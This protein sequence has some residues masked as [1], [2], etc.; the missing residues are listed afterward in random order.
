MIAIVRGE[1]TI[2]IL[3]KYGLKVCVI[4]FGFYSTH[5]KMYVHLPC[6]NTHQQ[7]I[8]PFYI[9]HVISYRNHQ[10][11][12]LCQGSADRCE[13]DLNSKIIGLLKPYQI[14][15]YCN[16]LLLVIVPYLN[17]IAWSITICD[18]IL[19]SALVQ[20]FHIILYIFV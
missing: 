3:N 6:I 5:H 4:S 19:R 11:P 9:N 13:G 10:T 20:L 18:L 7:S 12:R 2:L 14:I 8:A 17:I 1:F 16:L 15:Y